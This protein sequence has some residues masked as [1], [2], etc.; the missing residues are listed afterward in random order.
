MENL[1][2]TPKSKEVLLKLA[3]FAI[4]LETQADG[5]RQKILKKYI[6]DNSDSMGRVKHSYSYRQTPEFKMAISKAAIKVIPEELREASNLFKENV[7]RDKYGYLTDECNEV[8]AEFSNGKGWAGRVNEYRLRD[9]V[10]LVLNPTL[11]VRDI[12]EYLE[13]QARSLSRKTYLKKV[14]KGDPLREGLNDNQ[15]CYQFTD[16]VFDNHIDV[17]SNVL[18][19]GHQIRIV[20]SDQGYDIEKLNNKWCYV[21]SSDTLT[22]C[23]FELG[24]ALE[25]IED[26][27]VKTAVKRSERGMCISDARFTASE[28][29]QLAEAR[30][31]TLPEQKTF[32]VVERRTWNPI[33]VITCESVDKLNDL[34]KVHA[35]GLDF[36]EAEKL[37]EALNYLA[38]KRKVLDNAQEGLTRMEKRVKEA[39]DQVS[40]AITNH[41]EAIQELTKVRNAVGLT[42]EP[43]QL[44]RELLQGTS[45]KT[46]EVAQ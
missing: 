28:V 36:Q 3:P 29:R 32:S 20:K 34:V 14:A 43:G 40:E 42:P 4:S 31:I 27:A 18:F 17:F 33:D 19:I 41:L 9:M 13:E 2:F 16:A 6:E 39:K 15:T 35:T 45:E 37:R 12:T 26:M 24:E 22:K 25:Y 1:K 23:I 11:E 46:T 44:V 5:L 8:L 30:G 21:S 38:A 7:P 10:D